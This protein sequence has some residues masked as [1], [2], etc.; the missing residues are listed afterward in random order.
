[1]RIVFPVID[2]LL[3]YTS[4]LA[5]E[6]ARRHQVSLVILDGTAALTG[7]RSDFERAAREILIPE[8]ELVVVARWRKRDI[9]SM[10]TVAQAA[11]YT[12]RFRPDMFHLMD[13]MD[14]RVL[15]LTGLFSRVPRVLT[16][17]DVELH[18]G[19]EHTRRRFE[20]WLRPVVRRWV[21]QVVVHGESLRDKII[22]RDGVPPERIH[23]VPM[24][25]DTLLHR[26]AIPGLKDDGRTVLFFG[27][28]W[29]YKG[30]ETLARAEPLITASFPDVRIVVAGRGPDLDHWIPV[31]E[32]RRAFDIIN[33]FVSDRE[34]AELFQKASV[35]VLPYL[36]ASQSAVLTTAYAFGK[37]VVASRVGGLPDLVDDGG[38]GLLVP[39]GDAEALADAVIKLLSDDKLR[40]RIGL[41]AAHKAKDELSWAAVARQTEDIYAQSVSS[42]HR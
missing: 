35:V 23:V 34:A 25:A 13:D 22:A 20:V 7:N 42:S 16:V 15:M 6:L 9:R 21:S 41:N 12:H 1:M 17:H 36:Q 18:L 31:L 40:R 29:R 28:M 27:R 32:E 8:V 37:P 39:P 3:R 19:E 4:E 2:G 33:D 38:T 11:A 30:L 14:Y 24:G 10:W 5:N 26:W